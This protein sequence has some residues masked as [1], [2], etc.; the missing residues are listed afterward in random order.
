MS[1]TPVILD[2]FYVLIYAVIYPVVG[3]LGYQQMLRMIK[4]G[5]TLPRKLLYLTTIAGQWTIM[6]IGVVLWLSLDRPW[7]SMGFSFEPD[8]KFALGVLLSVIA[9]ALLIKQIKGIPTAP[10]EDIQKLRRQFEPVMPILPQTR[11]EL[12]MFY[13]LSVTAGIVEEVLWRGALI[14]YLSH[15]MPIWAAAIISAV[16]FGLAH[17]YQG[18]AQVPQVIA[19]GAVF[20][21]LYL[22]T[23]S[24]WVPIVLH[25][26]FD[27][28]QGRLA[29]DVL[30]HPAGRDDV[31]PTPLIDG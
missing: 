9:M 21:A 24:V 6:F 11:A 15:Y 25:A 1:A 10:D 28:L 26:V 30:N 19:V 2:H 5:E 20:T 8:W 18:A 27:I 13:R 14:W 7:S 29:Y 22:L 23:G 3:Y 16:G 4:A 12:G 31:E 17:S